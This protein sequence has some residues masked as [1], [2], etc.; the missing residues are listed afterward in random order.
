ME[1]RDPVTA[2]GKPGRV[3]VI[4]DVAGVRKA[5]RATLDNAGYEVLE[6]EDGEQAIGMLQAMGD[7]M[8]VDVI[9]SD[10]RMPPMKMDGAKV[11]A[12]FRS[13]YPAVPVVALTAYPDVELAV[14]LMRQGV[15]DFLVKPV[16]Q[17]ELLSVV[18]RAV[19]QDARRKYQTLR[20]IF[21]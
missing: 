5:I 21:I 18:E 9:L 3:L 2:N 11:I 15:L 12:Y 14:S 13:R 1:W 7:P 16:P 19:E 10:L 17:N 6:A 8:P 20:N 4:D